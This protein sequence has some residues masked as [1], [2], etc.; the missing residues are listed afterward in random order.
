[1]KNTPAFAVNPI[2]DEKVPFILF[3]L[4]EICQNYLH[5]RNEINKIFSLSLSYLGCSD[6]IRNEKNQFHEKADSWNGKSNNN[7]VELLLFGK[8]LVSVTQRWKNHFRMNK[9]R[10]NKEHVFKG[11]RFEAFRISKS[12]TWYLKRSLRPHRKI[13]SK[14][15]SL[16]VRRI[17]FHWFYVSSTYVLLLSLCIVYTHKV[18][19]PRLNKVTRFSVFRFHSVVLIVT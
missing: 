11:Q 19:T 5:K 15:I 1:M 4:R 16:Y 10:K 9:I 12:E 2:A 17:S 6:W 13:F 3:S 7:D 8:V 18:H 14:L